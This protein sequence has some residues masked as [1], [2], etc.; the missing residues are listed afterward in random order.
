MA[1]TNETGD[2]MLN[3]VGAVYRRALADATRGDQEAIAW[4]SVCCPD[5]RERLGKRK[6]VRFD[7]SAERLI[8][9]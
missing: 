7:R 3:V 5:W 2:P 4:L 9:A 1:T 6:A 8:S